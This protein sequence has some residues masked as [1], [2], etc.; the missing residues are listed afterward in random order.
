MVMVVVVVVTAAVP[1]ITAE[2]KVAKVAKVGLTMMT[3]EAF[4]SKSSG[5]SR[6]FLICGQTNFYDLSLT[7]CR[8]EHTLTF[9]TKLMETKKSQV[10]IE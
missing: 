1:T 7:F 5:S 6:L 10:F 3:E 2:T 8:C 4:T 9:S